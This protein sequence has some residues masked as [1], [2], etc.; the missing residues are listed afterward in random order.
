VEWYHVCWP[1]LTAKRVEPVVSISW[2]SCLWSGWSAF[3]VSTSRLS[4]SLLL[5]RTVSLDIRLLKY[6]DLENCVKRPWRSLKM[7]LFNRQPVTSYYRSILCRF[8]DIQCRKISW[9][10]NSGQRSLKVIDS[11]TT[12]KIGY[13]FLLVLY[14]KF[15]PKTSLWNIRQWPWNPG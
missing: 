14:N 3:A 9:P 6:R 4:L 11:G 2:A 5:R 12:G 7:S 13:G 10:W 15:V 8:W 1:R